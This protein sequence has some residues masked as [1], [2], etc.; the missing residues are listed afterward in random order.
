MRSA[1]RSQKHYDALAI[2]CAVR[3]ADPD[4]EILFGWYREQRNGRLGTTRLWKFV[5]DAGA[6]N[7]AEVY[8][9]TEEEAASA[10]LTGAPVAA[11]IEDVL[12]RDSVEGYMAM[13]ETC[14]CPEAIPGDDW[15]DVM[16][17]MA[18]DGAATTIEEALALVPKE[19]G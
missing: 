4:G 5:V 3:T 1:M 6:Q 15:R 11:L 19:E 17:S 14:S 2:L 13:L 8:D 18:L 16:D 7:L 9:L 10:C 12:W